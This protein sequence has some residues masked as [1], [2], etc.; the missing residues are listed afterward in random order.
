MIT[1]D[2]SQLSQSPVEGERGWLQ[3]LVAP[4]ERWTGYFDSLDIAMDRSAPLA[5]AAGPR[6][7]C[8]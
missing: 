5:D 3:A 2:S 7:Y 1:I 6:G 8:E 4:L